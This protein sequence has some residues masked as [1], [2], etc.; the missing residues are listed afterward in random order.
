MIEDRIQIKDLAK[1][2]GEGVACVVTGRLIQHSL[3]TLTLEDET[4]RRTF[5]YPNE[6]PNLS[7]VRLGDILWIKMRFENNA[8]RVIDL[9]VLVPCTLTGDALE[10]WLKRW[11]NQSNIKRKNIHLR[12]GLMQSIR[13]YFTRHDFMEASTPTLVDCPGM[14]PNLKG[15]DTEWRGPDGAYRQQLFLPT[16]PEFNLKKMLVLGYERVFEF[17]RCFRNGELSDLHQPEFTMLEWYRAY[18]GYERIMEDVEDMICRSAI[19]LF[20][21]SSIFY[22]GCTIE[23]N[24]PWE[25]ISVK[26]LFER[27]LKIDLDEVREPVDFAASANRAGYN[28]VKGSESFDD[29]FFKLFLTEIESKLGWEKPVILYDYPIEM[30]ALSRKKPGSPRYCERFEVYIAGI[31]LANAFG[32]LNN[33]NEQCKRFVEFMRLSDEERGYHYQP[34][35]EFINALKFGMPPSAGIALGFDR[36]SMI[37]A[38]APS[39]EEVCSFPHRSPLDRESNS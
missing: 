4:D 12:A 25:R 17:A 29:I 38:N 36:L 20:G 10:R 3:A 6:N 8:W 32:E 24:P 28:Y 14:E 16:S 37:F 11:Q 22:E 23:L 27:K 26:D 2:E 33:A 1:R 35:E 13:G 7:K 18:S 30:A 34:D 9:L 19:E 31:E 5:G 15:F 39:L 21:T